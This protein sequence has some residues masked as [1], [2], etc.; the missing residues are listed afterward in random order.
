MIPWSPLAGGLLGGA[1]GKAAE[2]RR[3]R[4]RLQQGDRGASAP[5][6]EEWEELCGELGEEP[7]DVALAWLLHSPP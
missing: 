5:Q 2:G 1:L 7:A 3:A 6:L 4:E